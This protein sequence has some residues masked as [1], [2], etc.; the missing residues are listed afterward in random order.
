MTRNLKKRNWF[1]VIALAVTLG[2]C[3]TYQAN[4]VD[5]TYR[6]LSVSKTS[7]E[8]AMH[9]AADLDR[10]GRLTE[11]Q[12]S[13]VL[14]YGAIYLNA[15]IAAVEALA[16]YAETKNKTDQDRFESQVEIAAEALAN[17]LRIIESY[18]EA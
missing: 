10:K 13:D 17:L 15:H 12:R 9:I 4:L 3:A 1:T 7:Y 14:E 8:T 2:A 11:Q 16:K 18:V 6:I 5:S